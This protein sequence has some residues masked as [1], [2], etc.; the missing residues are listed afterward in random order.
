MP[1]QSSQPLRGKRFLVTR[2]E[3]QA[4]TLV[5]GIRAL[6]GEASHIPWLAIEPLSEVP[7]L[8]RIARNLDEYRA[9]LFVS[10]NA[11]QSAWPTLAAVPWPASVAAA[12]VGPGTARALRVLGVPQVIFPVS[13]FD[14]EGLLAESFFADSYCQGQ[15]FA[16]IRGE[17][18]RDFLAQ[19]LRARGARVDE[20]AVYRRCLHPHALHRLEAWLGND[21]SDRAS[22]TILVSSSESL[23]RVIAAASSTLA[24]RLRETTLLVPHPKIAACARELGF[25]RVAISDGGDDGLLDFLRSYNGIGK[26]ITTDETRAS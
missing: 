19:S 15:A 24:A 20:A 17:G 16:L 11:V 8:T 23:Q 6:G 18:G 10:A 1:A 22:D 21:D 13:R 7:A 3:G 9:C 25:Q 26:T 12:T 4:S 14:S 5:D 2:P